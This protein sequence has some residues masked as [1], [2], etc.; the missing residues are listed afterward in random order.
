MAVALFWKFLSFL[1]HYIMTQRFF[2]LI[3]VALC[4][5]FISKAAEKD[6]SDHPIGTRIILVL[7]PSSISKLDNKLIHKMEK[8]KS[9]MPEIFGTLDFDALYACSSQDE[10]W[11]LKDLSKSQSLQIQ[12][13]NSSALSSSLHE[14]YA[15]NQGKTVLLCVDEKTMPKVLQL[16]S[17]DRTY[18]KMSVKDF[19]KIYD[20]DSPTL[21]TGKVRLINLENSIQ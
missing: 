4:F 8:Q 3:I 19:S 18:G 15:G 1:N 14:M 10:H 5:S 11:M 20:I 6:L 9:M 16:L 12:T 17:G 13:F 21:G 2:M 7:Q